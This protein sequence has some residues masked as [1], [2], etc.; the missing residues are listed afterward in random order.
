MLTHV[1]GAKCVSHCVVCTWTERFSAGKISFEDGHCAGRPV[2]V[3]NERTVLLLKNLIEE[4]PH[5]TIHEIRERFDVS[6]GTEKIVSDDLNL[7][8]K[9]WQDVYSVS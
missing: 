7:K 5:I 8:E 1:Y 3:R 9:S 6:I 4:N 2:S